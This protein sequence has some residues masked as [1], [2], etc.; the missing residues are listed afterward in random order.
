VNNIDN[1]NGN[2]TEKDPQSNPDPII[3]ARDETG[4][5]AEIVKS[6]ETFISVNKPVRLPEV[7]PLTNHFTAAHGSEQAAQSINNMFKSVLRFKWTIILV[8]IF[9]TVPLSAIIWMEVVPEYQARAEVRVRPI[10]PYLVFRT[11]DNGMIPLYT[12]FMNTQVSIMRSLTVLQ[13]VLDRPEIQATKWYKMPDTSFI[14]LVLQ[15][16]SI[17]PLERLRDDLSVRPRSQTEIIDISFAAASAD[18]AKLIVNTVLE[19]YIKY[20]GEMSDTTADELY[21]QLRDQYTSLEGEIQGRETLIAGL[22]KKIGS[23]T[24]EE[25]VANKRLQLDQIQLNLNELQQQISLLEWQ[26]NRVGESASDSNNLAIADSNQPKYYEDSEWRNQD[27]N[28]RTIQHQIDN[29]V[30]TEK[31]PEMIRLQKDLDFARELLKLRESQLDEQWRNKSQSTTA[32]LNLNASPESVEFQLNQAKYE[33]E[34]VNQEYKKQQAEFEELFKSA[35]S[36]QK[37]NNELAYKRELFEEVRLRR[38]Q[39]DMERNVP[40][41]IDVLMRAF[42]SSKPYNDRRIVFTMMVIFLGLCA[43]GGTAVLRAGRNQ[44]VYTPQDIPRPIQL[45]FLGYVPVINLK[46]PLG[47]GLSDEIKQKQFVLNESI[48]VMR[49]ALLSRLNGRNSA[50]ILITSS[51][52]GTGKSSFTNTLGHSIAQTGKTVIIVDTDFHKKSLSGWYDL[53]DKPGFL[54]CLNDVSAKKTFIYRTDIPSLSIM[55]VGKCGK[56]TI[57][58]EDIAKDSFQRFIDRLR[59]QYQIILLDCAPILSVADAIIMSHHVDGSVLVE[60]ELVSQRRDVTDAIARLHS[61]GGRLFGFAFVGSIDYQKDGYKNYYY[62]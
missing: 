39:K 31:N 22:I 35:Q 27:K 56:G 34:L 1:Y 4:S 60:R 25:L 8:F 49:T 6:E 41:A 32:G 11:E 58:F 50:S 47:K 38:E 62:S 37:E 48:R 19:Q 53:Q 61:A 13:R 45:P 18:D 7:V 2:S 9:L 59:Q 24:P 52:P 40:G 21:R 43:G 17:P 15:N 3:Q 14:A 36:L 46:K 57:A 12:S 16:I 42:V 44:V 30:L 23:G 5:N 26:S 54:E 28:V 33:A 10:I 51:I 29:S 20:I 55:P